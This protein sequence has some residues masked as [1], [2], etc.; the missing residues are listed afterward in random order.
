MDLEI[1]ILFMAA[2]ILNEHDLNS[3]PPPVF[4]EPIGTFSCR[5]YLHTYRLL[6]QPEENFIGTLTEPK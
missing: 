2:R 3:L 5:T 6:Y 4:E 1:G